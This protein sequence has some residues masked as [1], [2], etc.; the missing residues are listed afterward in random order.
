MPGCGR[1]HTVNSRTPSSRG[2]GS[3]RERSRESQSREERKEATRRAIGAM[4][5]VEFRRHGRQR[6]KNVSQEIAVF[7]AVRAEETEGG[8]AIDPVCRMAVD[9]EHAQ[10]SLTY[11]GVVYVF[12]SLDCA[13]KFAMQP[14]RYVG[15]R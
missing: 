4:E 10:G 15:G 13:R 3:G 6:F 5:G 12:C 7:R 2:R 8:L 14:E 9:T 11:G 1:V